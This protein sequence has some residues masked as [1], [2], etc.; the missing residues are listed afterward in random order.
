MTTSSLPARLEF[1]RPSKRLRRS[2]NIC[3]TSSDNSEAQEQKPEAR[4]YVLRS[5][6]SSISSERQRGSSMEHSDSSRHQDKRHTLERHS[7][8]GVGSSQEESETDNYTSE[9]E[10]SVP[11]F[12]D[13]S[14]Y[15]SDFFPT[16]ILSLQHIALYYHQ[17]AP[18]TH[19][20]RLQTSPLSLPT[21]T[22]T[23]RSPSL[24]R[25]GVGSGFGLLC[26]V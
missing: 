12:N 4:E 17:Q 22:L 3:T 26:E 13:I 15:L 24:R 6:N 5:L 23:F 9:S 20:C 11:C 16:N 18:T 19:R 21:I 7:P 14:A 10:S 2:L 1:N 25:S 8:N